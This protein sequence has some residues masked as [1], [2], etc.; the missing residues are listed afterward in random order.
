MQRRRATR[1]PCGMRSARLG[2]DDGCAL[3]K[4]RGSL[5]LHAEAVAGQHRLD[6]LD[7][8]TDR[9]LEPAAGLLHALPRARQ[10]W[11]QPFG[12]Q[13]RFGAADDLLDI[14]P[15]SRLGDHELAA[16]SENPD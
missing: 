7:T 11:Q 1:P 12:F 13:A 2:G 16:R 15:G 5:R 3:A 4:M 9:L 6:I 8:E 10:R 14:E